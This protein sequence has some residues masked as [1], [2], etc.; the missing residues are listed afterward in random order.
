MGFFDMSKGDGMGFAKIENTAGFTNEDLF[1]KL[2][3]V[4][5]S[6]GVP[7]MGDIKGTPSVM[8]SR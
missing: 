5:V 7:V 3:A 1:E 4:K 8:L 2:S 6:F